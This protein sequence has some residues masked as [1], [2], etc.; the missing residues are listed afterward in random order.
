M[1]RLQATLS[2]AIVLSETSHVFCCVLPVLISV[3]SLLT[4]LG[5]ASILP[6]ALLDLHEM[7]HRWEVPL[8]I[9]SGSVMAFGWVL[10]FISLKIDCHDTGCHHGP[11]NPKK[12]N[13]S[14]ILAFASLLFAINIAVYFGLH[15]G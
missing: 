4:G 5:A 11:C 8:I 9:F 7:M 1:K 13:A 6:S 3:L 2:W 15:A 14:R 12:K 10:Y